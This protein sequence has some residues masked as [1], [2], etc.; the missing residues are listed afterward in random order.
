M[1]K[2]TSLQHLRQQSLPICGK[3]NPLWLDA[4][5]VD[6]TSQTRQVDL[7]S[8]PL[9]YRGKKLTNKHTYGLNIKHLKTR[10]SHDLHYEQQPKSTQRARSS[11]ENLTLKRMSPRGD[12]L[13]VNFASVAE[14]LAARAWLECWPVSLA[15]RL[16][17]APY[18]LRVA[19]LSPAC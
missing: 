3:R 18:R 10:D 7:T 11:A 14:R 1:T 15:C 13:R 5:L 17:V 8:V 4:W 2:G 19:C 9:N 6:S 12:T 16:H